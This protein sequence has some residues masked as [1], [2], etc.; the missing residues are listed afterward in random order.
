MSIYATWLMMGEDEDA[1]APIVYRGSHVL[2]SDTDRR[3]GG[4]E[5]GAIPDYVDGQGQPTGPHD[6]LRVSVWTDQVGATVLLDRDQVER[7]RDQL[8]VWLER[9]PDA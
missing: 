1:T 6:L 7:V 4:F 9:E 8:S 5:L 2:P 3:G